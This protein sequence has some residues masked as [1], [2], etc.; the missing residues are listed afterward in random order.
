LAEGPERLIK[1]FP[2]PVGWG[3]PAFLAPLM[4]GL[5]GLATRPFLSLR[6]GHPHSPLPGG[7]A[8]WT[9]IGPPPLTEGSPAYWVP[10][11][12]GLLMWAARPLFFYFGGTSPKPPGRGLASPLHPRLPTLVGFGFAGVFGPPRGGVAGVGTSPLFKSSWGDT[13]RSHPPGGSAPWTPLAHP[14]WLGVCQRFGSP[15]WWVDPSPAP[16]FARIFPRTWLETTP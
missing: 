2:T 13:P 4:A 9:P 1:V 14:R 6:G 12:A 3:S 10:L 7:S 16:A 5:Q 11:V 15:S 8:P